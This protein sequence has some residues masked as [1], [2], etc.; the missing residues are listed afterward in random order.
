MSVLTN[1]GIF[2]KKQINSNRTNDELLL[3]DNKNVNSLN[4]ID[5][6]NKEKNQQEKFS[7]YKKVCVKPF[8]QI[9]P[10]KKGNINIHNKIITTKE[11]NNI[12]QY[13]NLENKINLT[14]NDLSIK[15]G[16]KSNLEINDSSLNFINSELSKD[17]SSEKNNKVH[18]EKEIAYLIIFP[19]LERRINSW[20]KII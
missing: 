18:H 10:N 5:I 11:K 7:F 1:K 14:N 8:T 15:L 16:L 9:K 20:K 17:K 13:K 6:K 19:L 12:K 2:E 3:N 4:N